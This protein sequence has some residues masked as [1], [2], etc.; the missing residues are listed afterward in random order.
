MGPEE[1]EAAALPAAPA[2]DGAAADGAAPAPVVAATTAV[3]DA[4]EEATPPVPAA[5]RTE[6]TDVQAGFLERLSSYRQA[7]PWPEKVEGIQEY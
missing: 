4:A 3:L 5:A 7:S 1:P 6:E 2:A